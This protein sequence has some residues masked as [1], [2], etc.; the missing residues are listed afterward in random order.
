[1]SVSTLFQQNNNNIYNKSNTLTNTPSNP[2]GNTNTLWSNSGFNPP[3]LMYGASDV[4]A[5]INNIAF[6]TGTFNLQLS[7][8]WASPISHAVSYTKINNLV[9]L[10]I[11]TYQAQATTLASISSIVGALPTNLRPVNNP[12]IDFEI[13]VLD[14]GTRTTNP[15]LITLLSNGQ[16]LIY[17]DNN[18]GQFTVG[19]G[20]SGFNPFSITY[21]I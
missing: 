5:A 19:S 18:L 13:F 9:N 1:M 12:E 6:E 14:N 4:T 20:G 8:P 21:M 11:P 15:G 17:K 10:T 7:G 16:I 3:H 2:T